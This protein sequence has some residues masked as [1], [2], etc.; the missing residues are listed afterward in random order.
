MGNKNN[1]V[2]K[3]KEMNKQE[4]SKKKMTNLVF[5]K[6]NKMEGLKLLRESRVLDPVLKLRMKKF[7]KKIDVEASAYFEV[8]TEIM[9]NAVKGKDKI[10][11]YLLDEKGNIAW[12][13]KKT[14]EKAIKEIGDLVNAEFEFDKPLQI[15]G[16]L[17]PKG[18][19][20]TNDEII[21]ENLGIMVFN[22]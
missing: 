6:L 9:N 19:L 21:L 1:E 13:N 17:V 12:K 10:G 4:Q 3:V 14:G 5:E 2:S 15:T 22:D 18:T 7:F 8:K 11:N 20:S 16:K